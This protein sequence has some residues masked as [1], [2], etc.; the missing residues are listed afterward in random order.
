MNFESIE[1]ICG[2]AMEPTKQKIESPF[3]KMFMQKP[4]KQIPPKIASNATYYA[5]KNCESAELEG[6][7]L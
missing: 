4:Q 1:D 2:S 6:D 3:Q 5:M 7:L